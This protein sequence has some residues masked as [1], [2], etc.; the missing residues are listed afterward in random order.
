[1]DQITFEK[2]WTDDCLFEIKVRASNE[3]IT[4]YQYCYVDNN[5]IQEASDKILNY[6]ANYK[7][8]VVLEFGKKT[9]KY[10]PAFSMSI[11]PADTRGHLKIEMDMEI[12]DNDTRSHRCCFYVN[13]ELGLLERF[14]KQLTDLI[15]ETEG[16]TCHLLNPEF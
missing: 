8:P 11:L 1:M 13:T 4:A 16:I 9:G 6:I 2:V 10:T 3:F 14:G 12:N 7:D 15:K 5:I